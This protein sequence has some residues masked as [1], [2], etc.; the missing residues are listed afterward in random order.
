[1]VAS[2]CT[3]LVFVLLSAAGC[4]K[5]FSASNA[6]PLTS[7]Q[8]AAGEG[9]SGPA[10]YTGDECVT[11]G[12]RVPCICTDGLGQGIKACAADKT[13]PT[14]GTYSEC[15]ACVAVPE[16]GHPTVAE[17]PGRTPN[18]G[19][20]SRA[21]AGGTTSMGA[22]G[23]G[24]TSSARAGSGGRGT[25]A[26]AGRSGGGTT[27]SSGRCNCTQDCFP[28]GILACCRIDNSCGCSWAPGAYCL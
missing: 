24:A 14:L 19:R 27:M 8:E 22:A 13:S 20:G 1:M 15:T 10:M 11:I 21:G 28:V 6:A 3:W 23:T 26:A 16:A 4:A 18:A 25:T 12:E 2:R 7:A 17:N 5:G 9:S